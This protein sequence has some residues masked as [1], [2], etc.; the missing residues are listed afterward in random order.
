MAG[1]LGEA[2]VARLARLGVGALPTELG[3][4]LFDRALAADAALLA[5]VRVDPAAL[6]AQARAGTLPAL[7]RG[8]VPARRAD[9][10]G[11]LAQR[12][13]GVPEGERERVVLEV[14]QAQVAAVLGHA[15]P[16]A[17][18]AGRA[19]RDLG[20]DSLAAVELRNRLTQAT[21]ERLPA[22]LVF[23]YPTPGAIAQYLVSVVTP[24]GATAG[25]RSEE[26][27]VRALVASIPVARLRQAGLLGTLRE[28]AKGDPVAAPP[29]GEAPAAIDDMDAAA[30]LRMAREGA[31]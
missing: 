12:L 15:S 18:D 2:D 26:D 9:T 24:A 11:S 28:L 31:G 30:L 5:P 3:L 25:L 17:V 10:G 8:L 6:R 13:A 14:V 1:E 27:E 22:T 29:A 19:L 21:G 4:A 20:F 16:A 23:D 7:L